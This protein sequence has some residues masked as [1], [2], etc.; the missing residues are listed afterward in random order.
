MAAPRSRGAVVMAG[1]DDFKAEAMLTIKQLRQRAERS[2]GRKPGR[3]VVLT[4]FLQVRVRHAEIAGSVLI[5]PSKV[6]AWSHRA[7]GG[8]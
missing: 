2:T 6:E 3:N 7:D 4:A 5:Y 1:P 8:R